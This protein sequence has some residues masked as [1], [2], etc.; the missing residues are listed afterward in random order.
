MLSLLLTLSPPLAVAAMSP[1]EH[2]QQLL[3][4]GR[5]GVLPGVM[6]EQWTDLQRL[7]EQRDWQLIWSDANGAPLAMRRQQLAAWVVLSHAHGLDPRDYGVE[8]LSYAGAG[9]ADLP[10]SLA[11]S[12]AG[13]VPQLSGEVLLND[14]LMSHA[15]I[16]LAQDLSGSRL[17]LSQIDPLWRLPPK[18]LDPVA[19]LQRLEQ[20]VSVDQLLSELLPRSAEYAR[21]VTLHQ[22]LTLQAQQPYQPAELPTGLLRA[23]DRHPGVVQLRDWLSHQGVL[24]AA[25]SSLE[26]EARYTDRVAEAVRQYQQQQ[27]LKVDGIYGPDTRAAMLTSPAQKLQQ[28]RANLAR[29]RAL[30][31]SLGDRYLLVRTASFSLDLVEQGQVVERHAIITGRPARPSLSFATEVDK[32]ILNPSWTVPFRLAVEDLLPKQQQDPDYFERLGIEVLALQDGHWKPVDS[33]SIDWSGLSRQ[34]FRYLLRQRP[35]PHNS[36]G[37]IRFGM[38]NPHSIFLHDTPQQSLFEARSRAFSSG[39]IRVQGIGQLAQT[40]LGEASLETQLSEETTRHLPLAQPL[41]VYLVY[42]SVWVDEQQQAHFYADLYGTD[43]RMNAVL[44]PQPQPPSPQLMQ[45]AQKLLKK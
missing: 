16:R 5:Q 34:N 38:A 18:S 15:F 21:L 43:A 22:E 20:G 25:E 28:V 31:V 42:L 8:R 3:V 4:A 32:L 17:D 33:A 12:A 45:L 2:L 13:S 29:W 27:G 14:L 1:G 44:G 41:P 35:G 19:L 36:L 11:L 10:S 9:Y 30:P 37:R 26:E 39:C 6:I 40:L 24:N 7:Y 23:G